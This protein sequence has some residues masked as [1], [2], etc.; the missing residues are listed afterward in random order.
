MSIRKEY[1]NSTYSRVAFNDFIFLESIYTQSNISIPSNTSASIVITNFFN[2]STSPTLE[3]GTLCIF[4]YSET[5]QS[6]QVGNFNYAIVNNTQGSFSGNLSNGFGL[7]QTDG[8][9]ISVSRTASNLL[10][11]LDLTNSET[12]ITDGNL[13][14]LKNSYFNSSLPS[15][16]TMLMTTILPS[17]TLGNTILPKQAYQ[18]STTH[19]TGSGVNYLFTDFFPTSGIDI[20]QAIVTSTGAAGNVRKFGIINYVNYN[21][22]RALSSFYG[23][24]SGQAGGGGGS[25]YV[26]SVSGTSLQVNIDMTVGGSYNSSVNQRVHKINFI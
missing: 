24:A 2:P 1:T 20:G 26:A 8:A 16:K 12:A 23:Y 10:I 11:A 4:A 21:S 3:T 25:A 17:L 13:F 22:N 6:A 7:A 5:L 19:T 14:V 15:F 18:I 9:S